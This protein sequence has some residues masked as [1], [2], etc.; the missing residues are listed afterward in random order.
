[1]IASK[2]VLATDS[3]F[4]LIDRATVT[5]SGSS[6]G[7]VNSSIDLDLFFVECRVICSKRPTIAQM[8]ATKSLDN[9]M[10]LTRLAL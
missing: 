10:L 6:I 9:V 7:A 5:C 4:R 8:K 3:A 1:M 2:K